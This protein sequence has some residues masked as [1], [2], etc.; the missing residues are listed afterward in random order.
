[1]GWEGGGGGGGGCVCVGGGL[2]ALRPVK[3]EETVS[4]S[5]NNNV[6][7]VGTRLVPRSLCTSLTAVS[8]VCG[9]VTK[10]VSEK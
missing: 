5:Q 6:K 7:E 2:T 10:T 9:T 1:M 4:H 3:T 8:A